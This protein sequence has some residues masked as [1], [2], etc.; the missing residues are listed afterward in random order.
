MKAGQ[1]SV[2][3]GPQIPMLDLRRAIA[4]SAPQWR[5]NLRSSFDRSQFISGEQC[6]RFEEEF[7]ASQGARFAVG[8][9]SG[10]AALE[11]SLRAAGVANRREV[12]LPAL[13]SPFSALAILAAGGVPRFA[14]V[15]A[16]SLL[17]DAEDAEARTTKR[18]AALMPVHLYGNLCEMRAFSELARRKGMVL[19]Q[20]A[21]QAHGASLFGRPLTEFS[22]CTAYSFYPTKNLGALGDGGAIVTDRASAARQLRLLRDGGRRGDQV[23]RVPGINSRLDE[24]QCCYLRAFLPRLTEWNARRARIA[25][26][27]DDALAECEGIRPVARGSGSVHHLYVARA[28]RRNQLRNF[29]L[30]RGISSAV[31]YPVPLH[32]QPAFRDCGLRRGDLPVAERACHEIISLPLWPY[33][34]ESMARAVADAIRRFYK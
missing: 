23:S 28:A 30:R 16:D 11:L 20:D 6:A 4:V 9:G 12:I 19:V 33:M 29:L 26:L 2:R 1:L 18:A 5:A 25:E 31:H 27:Y 7:A 13:T 14:D 21:C 34:P 8:V 32:L 15:K 24:I 3:A 17:L 10:T 22:V